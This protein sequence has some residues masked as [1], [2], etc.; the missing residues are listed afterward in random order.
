MEKDLPY[1]SKLAALAITSSTVGGST[2]STWAK[3]ER[4][5]RRAPSSGSNFG[6]TVHR[7][8]H[9]YNRRYSTHVKLYAQTQAETLQAWALSN[10]TTYNYLSL[11][12]PIQEHIL[13]SSHGRLTSHC[14]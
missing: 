2:S 5:Q 14:S 8:G 7:L 13:D 4:V 1:G 6:M 10:I 3:D 12:G 11:Q 9:V